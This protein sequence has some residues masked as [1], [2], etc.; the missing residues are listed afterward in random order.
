MANGNVE[1]W[2]Q[3][4]TI[5]AAFAGAGFGAGISYYLEM[6]RRRK[7]EE[8]SVNAFKE[9]ILRRLMCYTLEV[10][11]YLFSIDVKFGDDLNKKNISDDLKDKFK[12][13]GFPLSRHAMVIKEKEDEWVITTE[14]QMQSS[15]LRKEGGKINVYLSEGERE[16]RRKQLIHLLK[17]LE[18]G[19]AS[20]LYYKIKP[21]EKR[22]EIDLVL[23]L[24]LY[25]KYSD[26]KEK[27]E[28][29]IN[30]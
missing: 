5:I 15:I 28:S 3:V 4:A 10:L 22:R 11:G 12:T 18:F 1:L 13:E 21:E 30:Q 8:R 2:I 7:D 23:D 26:A 29:L 9:R 27:I 14:I 16:E 25:K 20:T 24:L 19:D 17:S 6:G